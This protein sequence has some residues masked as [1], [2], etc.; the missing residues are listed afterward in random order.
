[1]NFK[2]LTDLAVLSVRDPATAVRAL[3]SLNLPMSLR[4]TIL[5]IS[6]LLSTLLAGL[7]RAMFPIPPELENGLTRILAQP[8]QLVGIQF[9]TIT[10]SAALM[11][12][13]GRSFGGKGDFADALLLVGWMQIMLVVLQAAQLVLLGIMPFFSS[14][15]S[16]ATVG[17][18][19]YFIIQ[20]AKA[21]H[22]FQSTFLVI[23]GFIG[24]VFV[25]GFVL[26]LIA[27]SMG[28]MPEVTP[29]EL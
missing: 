6:V 24:T 1:M 14:L 10:L 21:L 5:A 3:Q 7:A 25:V 16:L 2:D 28:I 20:F 29:H 8:F 18:F 4:W 9:V 27:A 15:L 11:A 22:G 26:S 12:G 13:V 17:L 19:L 23:L